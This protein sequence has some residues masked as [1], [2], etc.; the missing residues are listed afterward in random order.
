MM[1]ETTQDTIRRLAAVGQRTETQERRLQSARERQAALDRTAELTAC[2][3]A[4]TD[5]WGRWT[6]PCTCG[7]H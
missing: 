6:G 7:G 4:G 3:D 1:G 5:T 2:W